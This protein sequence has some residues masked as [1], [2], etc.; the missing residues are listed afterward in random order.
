MQSDVASAAVVRMPLDAGISIQDAI[1]SM[2][3]RANLRNIK[4]VNELPLHK[5]VEAMSGKPYRFVQIFEFCDALTAASMLDHNEDYAAFMPCRIALYQDTSGK[6][7]LITMDMDLLIH[8]GREL[9]PGLKK[10]ALEVRDTI[11]DIMKAG[12][13]GEL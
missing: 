11:Y 4:L 9:Q 5:Q 7:W 8:G 1:D 12:A 6:P 13:H 10:K 3:L 2:K